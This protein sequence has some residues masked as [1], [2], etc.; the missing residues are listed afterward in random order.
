MPRSFAT[1]GTM[2]ATSGGTLQISA[3][4]ANGA[5]SSYDVDAGSRIVMNGVTLTGTGFTGAPGTKAEIIANQHVPGLH[6]INQY[7][8]HK[9]LRR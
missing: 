8:L 3:S 7:L 9:R 5:G 4:V 2:R 1:N 6:G